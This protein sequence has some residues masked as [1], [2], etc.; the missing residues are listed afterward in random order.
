MVRCF[1]CVTAWHSRYRPCHAA[2]AL[3][4]FVRGEHVALEQVLVS[5]LQNAIDATG[6]AGQVAIDIAESETTAIGDRP[7]T[8]LV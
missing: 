7:I 1:C 5:L 4:L 6:Q 3:D 8:A 2:L